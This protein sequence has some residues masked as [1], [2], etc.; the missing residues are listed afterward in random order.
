M[1]ARSTACSRSNFMLPPQLQPEDI[2]GWQQHRMGIL[3]AS[4]QA[5]Q[6]FQLE[7]AQRTKRTLGDAM[8]M[9]DAADHRLLRGPSFYDLF[10]DRS[11][12]PELIRSGYEAGQHT[13]LTHS[14]P[15]GDRGHE[16]WQ[17]KGVR[18]E[19][20][21]CVR[22]DLRKH[23]SDRRGGG[24]GV[25]GRV[26]S[27]GREGPAGRRRPG[28]AGGRR[29]DAHARPGYEPQPPDG[30]E[31]A[32]EDKGTHVEPDAAEGPGLRTWLA[33]LPDGQEGR[34][35][36][37]DT[38][39][40]KAPWFTGVASRGI[41]KRLRRH[42]YKI[43]STESFLVEDSE[44]PLEEGEL[45]RARGWGAELAGASTGSTDTE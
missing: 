32:Q 3:E 1:R 6:G 35:A 19:R 22:V 5:E 41:A 45:D 33:D 13:P 38:R 2:T 28:P 17:R 34:A 20:S 9:I 31:A 29:A 26:R 39:L 16:P 10:I 24:G 21:S 18:H 40:D 44:G 8:T 12:W 30:G 43:V 7:L 27:V 11:R 37:F 42:G 14:V 23:A 15:G 4:R 36:A 25:R